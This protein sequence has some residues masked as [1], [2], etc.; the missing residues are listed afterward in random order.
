MVE[1]LASF[2]SIVQLFLEILELFPEARVWINHIPAASKINGSLVPTKLVGLHQISNYESGTTRNSREAMNEDIFTT[3]SFSYEWICFSKI[4]TNSWTWV[5]GQGN[6]KMLYAS[7]IP[8]HVFFIQYANY[9]SNIELRQQRHVACDW[10]V[11]DKEIIRH[12]CD[13]V[14][15]PFWYLYTTV[16]YHWITKLL[17]WH[18]YFCTYFYQTLLKLDG[19]W[20]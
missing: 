16:N 9:T 18:R 11:G 6:T 10:L 20:A 15:A 3:R 14:T 8:R 17:N 4:L 2:A 12:L 5:I 13:I 19:W 7:R 1:S